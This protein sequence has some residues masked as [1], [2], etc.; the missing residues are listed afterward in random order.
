MTQ[1][2]LLPAAAAIFGFG[3]AALRAWELATA[4]EP[5]TGLPIP[6]APA[7]LV[8]TLLSLLFALVS[9]AILWRICRKAPAR[10]FNTAF[11]CESTGYVTAVVS[12]AALPLC[13]AG[14]IV[15]DCLKGA[16]GMAHFLPAALFLFSAGS[17]VS[18][19]RNNYRNLEQGQ[20]T[21]S[22][23]LA[24][25][26]FCAHLMLTYQIHAGNPVLQDYAYLLLA[27]ICTVLGLYFM[28]SFSFEKGR[29]FLF[30]WT[31]GL[32]VYFSCITAV[33]SL[34]LALKGQFDWPN[35][36]LCL[37]SIVYFTVHGGVLLR[38]L[39]DKEETPHE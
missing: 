2:F 5:N 31:A 27:L 19:G 35:L 23:L 22:L 33:N 25:F 24:P 17:I 34:L 7:S 39:T 11:V 20:F 21:L 3:G 18:V 1:A 8:L 4:F 26:A 36:A 10:N 6:G 28:A 32:A 9:A 37:F 12:A 14:L 15:L 29:P 30:L 16:R 38:N 13:A